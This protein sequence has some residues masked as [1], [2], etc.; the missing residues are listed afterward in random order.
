[1][2]KART[3][4]KNRKYNRTRKFHNDYVAHKLYGKANSNFQQHPN[5]RTFLQSFVLNPLG[6][7]FDCHYQ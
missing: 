3:K 4:S 5:S 7:S 1:M 6:Q 2:V